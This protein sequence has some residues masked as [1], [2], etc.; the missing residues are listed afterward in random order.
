[1]KS[2]HTIIWSP[3]AKNQFFAIVDFIN[4]K[5]NKNT[6][7]KFIDKV[8]KSIIALQSMP[9]AFPE[10]NKKKIRRCVITKQTTVFYCLEKNSIELAAFFDTRQNPKKLKKKI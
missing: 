6:A 1:M 9:D 7:D 3:R 10:S 4:E 2:K 5:W 8:N